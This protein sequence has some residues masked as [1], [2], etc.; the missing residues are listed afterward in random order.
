MLRSFP[1]SSGEG[2]RSCPSSHTAPAASH[3][4]QASEGRA[5]D[6]KRHRQKPRLRRQRCL[7][8]RVTANPPQ[9]SSLMF[10]A[11]GRRQRPGTIHPTDGETHLPHRVRE[12]R[13]PPESEPRRLC[14][15]A[16]SRDP[17][18]LLP[19]W[20]TVQEQ[21]GRTGFPFATQGSIILMPSHW[22]ACT[23][24]LPLQSMDRAPQPHLRLASQRHLSQ[25]GLHLQRRGF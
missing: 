18:G 9:Q 21:I 20:K 3:A 7:Q 19:R 11:A 12:S 22:E 4:L 8:G 15:A 24:I 23:I 25:A 14:Q 1:A 17:A 2:R 6:S 10:L 13:S 5:G 16:T